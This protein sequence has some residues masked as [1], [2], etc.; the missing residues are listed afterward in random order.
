MARRVSGGASGEPSVGAIQVAPTA[1]VTA[2]TDQDI[3]LSPL[4]TA[5]VVFTNNAILNAQGDLRF[6]DADSSNWVAFQAPSTVAANVTWTLPSADGS[7]TQALTTNGSGT[8]S[9]ATPAIA[10]TDN[11]SDS[12]TNYVALTTANSGSISAARVSSTKLTFQPSTGNMDVSGLVRSNRTENVQTSNYT[13]ALTDRSAV[14]TMNN[15]STA[16]VTIPADSTV[17]FPIGSVVFVTRINSFTVTLAA[18]GGVTVNAGGT[19]NLALGE[20]VELRKRAANNWFVNQRP[21]SVTGSG[22]STSA[23][24]AV[25]VH[26]FTSGTSSFVVGT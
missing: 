4:G 14:V 3:T 8:L 26:Q 23:I 15:G 6:G 11:T 7:S 22:G 17:D 16:T 25:N 2:A 18:A 19:G 12:G 5:S 20:T 24:G 9:W 10:I 21:Y 13:L 1:V